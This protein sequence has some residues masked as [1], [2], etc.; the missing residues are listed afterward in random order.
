MK[1]NFRVL[2][3]I[4]VLMHFVVLILVLLVGF[5]ILLFLPP[6]T[7]NSKATSGSIS[8]SW[9]VPDIKL[10]PDNDSAKLITYGRELI[11]N[12][13]YYLGP[14]GSVRIMSNG[15][16]CQNC[17][18][19]AG[20]KYF[21]NNYLAVASTYPKY[22]SRSGSIESIEKRVNDCFQRSLN[23]STLDSTSLEMR[24]IVAY[25][26]WV[27]KD[28]K[29]GES[30]EGVGL[31]ALPFL[32][33]AA[34]PEIGRILYQQNCVTCH[35]DHGQGL[36]TKVDSIRYNPPLWGEHSYNTGAGLYRI[37]RLA[38]FVKMNMPLGVTY[39]A[40]SFSNE[41]AW[42]VAAYVSTMPRPTYDLGDDWPDISKKPFDHPFGPY[43]DDF[44]I[45]QH[46]YGPFAPIIEANKRLNSAK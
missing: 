13:S 42:D 12:T 24:A 18:L 26:Q 43:S 5:T 27:G 28:V 34:D 20:T 46:K 1:P 44:T 10:I 45:G 36:V 31:V 22:R 23:G 33:R 39:D 14:K 25:I 16:N 30:P 40:P 2:I 4:R 11:R 15:M 17:H 3:T 38:A 19:D 8:K 21:G 9:E 37:S 29:K 32:N 41:Q 35:G 7:F 6:E